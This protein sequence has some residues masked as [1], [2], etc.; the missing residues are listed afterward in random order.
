MKIYSTHDFKLAAYQVLGM[1]L[2][3][4]SI[5]IEESIKQRVKMPNRI[6]PMPKNGNLSITW[7]MAFGLLIISSL[8]ACGTPS[9]I[10]SVKSNFQIS[11]NTSAGI[12]AIERIQL[13]FGVGKSSTTVVQYS[14]IKPV[15]T[16]KYSGI[17]PFSAHWILDGQVIDQFNKT[18]NRGSILTLSPKSSISIPTFN[19]GRHLLQLKIVRPVVTFKQPETSFFVVAQ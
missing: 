15:A 18:L 17:G 7:L 6:S 8:T 9:P 2:K 19:L 10:A 16:I 3:N 12:L 4:M 5:R 14:E 13:D 11:G 1:R